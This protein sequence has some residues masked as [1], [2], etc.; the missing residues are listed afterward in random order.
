M[1]GELNNTWVCVSSYITA[2][3]PDAKEYIHC[4][5]ECPRCPDITF[6]RKAKWLIEEELNLRSKRG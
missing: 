5:L 2:L 6:C 4:I 1:I 3:K